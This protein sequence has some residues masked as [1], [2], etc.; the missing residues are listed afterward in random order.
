[1]NFWR[2]GRLEKL[3]NV[4]MS[5]NF[6]HFFK[7]KYNFVIFFF[8]KCHVPWKL[9]DLNFKASK[10]RDIYERKELQSCIFIWR[11]VKNSNSFSNCLPVL[12]LLGTT[13]IWIIKRATGSMLNHIFLWPWL[14]ALC[15]FR[16]FSLHAHCLRKLRSLRG[17]SLSRLLFHFTTRYD[18]ERVLLAF[19]WPRR[20]T[21]YVIA[22]TF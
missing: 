12:L 6:S 19:A 14:W 17:N 13:L 16:C 8:H 21:C 10:E 9:R 5:W 11:N 22:Y 2:W 1:M 18:G 3:I 4:K 15:C 7:W 20:P